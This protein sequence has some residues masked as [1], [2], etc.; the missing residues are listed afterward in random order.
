M[1]NGEVLCVACGAVCQQKIQAIDAS[2]RTV[3]ATTHSESAHE[4]PTPSFATETD[5]QGI[6]GWLVLIVIPLAIG[7]LLTARFLYADLHVLYGSNFQ[8]HLAANPGL[9]ALILFEAATNGIGLM[10][11]IGLNVL[12]YK[13]RKSFPGWMITY[14]VAILLVSLVDHLLTRHYHPTAPWVHVFQHLVAA[15]IWV[16]YFMRSRRVK[17]TFVN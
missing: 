2:E 3:P 1:P 9:A 12:F 8:S 7:P 11:V 16:P 17:Q 10:A 13:T 5:R 6:G 4:V 14:L 15:M